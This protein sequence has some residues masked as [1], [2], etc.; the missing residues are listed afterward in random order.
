MTAERLFSRR[1][2]I[3]TL[4]IITLLSSFVASLR[5]ADE[6]ETPVGVE[7]A[8]LPEVSVMA[9][10]E[11][12][13]VGLHIRHH[14]HF[15]TYWANPGIVGVPTQLE[16]KL[17]FGFEASEIQWPYPER[18]DMAGHPAHGFH[19]DVLLMVEITPTA[20]ISVERVTLEA[21]VIWMACAQT[22]HPG[23]TSL[24]LTLPVGEQSVRH[25]E[26]GPLFTAAE[27]ELPRALP[28]E[29]G[30]LRSV[31]EAD[32]IVFEFSGSLPEGEDSPYFY[33]SDGQVSS[34]KPQKWEAIEAGKWRVTLQRS[35]FGPA[36][37]KTL[38]G[39]LR[40]AAGWR[41]LELAY[42]AP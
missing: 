18:V 29:S 13:R 4:I 23:Q 36:G 12:F 42:P 6:G 38:P 24:A 5:A 11:P 28:A 21:G 25:G 30:R 9:P 7:L 26:N 31:R 22:C 41:T 32:E 14:S 35:D 37:K 39:V 3:K 16:W 34:E 1:G 8:L 27:K 17:P 2:G 15:H 20:E 40:T 10:G 33:S 19:R